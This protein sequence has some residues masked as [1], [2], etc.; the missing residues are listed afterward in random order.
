MF[1]A[2]ASKYI[3]RVGALAIALG[4]GGAVATPPWVASADETGSSS[5]ANP[6][7]R[8][9]TA[10]THRASRVR[11]VPTTGARRAPVADNLP[12]AVEVARNSNQ[13]PSGS[14]PVSV[15][16]VSVARVDIPSPSRAVPN[17]AVAYTAPEAPA[18]EAPGR[19]APAATA[20][21]A[22]TA[23]VAQAAPVRVVAQ[24]AAAVA[25]TGQLSV[26]SPS[27]SG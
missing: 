21:A 22:S 18:A 24:P 6:R 10:Q 16:G 9:N 13:Q 19:L 8:D 7:G 3:G 26:P 1:S 20:S 4:I 14:V 2:E 23:P 15:P 27:P 11:S 5:A 12:A 25:A 17:P